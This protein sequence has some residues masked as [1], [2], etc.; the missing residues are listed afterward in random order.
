MEPWLDLSLSASERANALL[1]ELSLDEKMA[2][3][4]CLFPYEDLYQDYDA[5]ETL[6]PFGIGEVSNLETQGAE[7]LEAAAC[8][9]RK[10]Q[11][12]VMANSPHRIP[13]IFHMEGLCGAVLH[14]ATSFPSGLARGSAFDPELEEAIG[15]TVSRQEAAVG[16]GHILAP[17]LDMARDPRLGRQGE[18]YGEDASLCAALGT[19]Y[20]RGVQKNEVA[21][22]HPE[23]VAKH[24]AAFHTSAGGIHGAHSE[25]SPRELEGSFSKPFQAAIRDAG[26]KGIMPCYCILDGEPAS[27]SKALLT[28]LLRE[29]LGFDGVAVSDYG[30][31]GNA[32]NCQHLCETIGE[33]GLRCLEA[34]TDVEMPSPAGYGPELRELFASGAADLSILDRAVQRV[35]EAKFRIG[36]FE[37]PFALEGERLRQTV[38]HEKEDRELTLRSAR[39]SLVLLKNDS[40]L[41][42]SGQIR[43]LAVIGP[44][45]DCARKMF[46]GY[47]H[48]S[49]SESTLAVAN[50]I[51]GVNG[52]RH[53]DPSSIVTVP[54]S[55]I[56][57]D[58]G[59]EF[60]AIL[61]RQ[62]PDC[63]SLLEELRLRLP[64]TEIRY[65]YGY[66]IAGADERGF[67][68]ALDAIREADAAILTLGGKYGTCSIASM[69]EGVDGT[70]INLPACQD[71]FI[72]AAAALG[73]PLIGL[74]F[75]GR[76]ISSDAADEHLSA[77]LECWTPAECG[78]QA[79]TD[80]LVGEVNPSGKLPVTV[81]RSAA[82]LPIYYDHPWN[83]MW[84]Q[85]GSIGFLN[86]VDMPHTP[87]YCFGHGLSYTAF[88]YSDLQFSRSEIAPD[89]SL[90][91]SAVI[92]N[93]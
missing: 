24:F 42:L 74:H 27:A 62:K 37:H 50:S 21:G 56:Q 36:L 38:V 49:M 14:D 33:T 90:D 88:V 9:Q 20:V 1:K 41:P 3:I 63:R 30:A 59:A 17:V 12:I 16:V 72:C 28:G 22:R 85:S 73:K 40:A 13:A 46:G 82:Q 89:A 67:D 58:E 71:A 86:Y 44:H 45:A 79:V 75:D 69:G 57:S 34:G 53:A 76:P 91:I 11:S 66:P 92:T 7:T 77:I 39:E 54:G 55:F 19:A 80:V 26:L 52:T 15:E 5:I 32:H 93:T 61:M 70:D 65:A 2:Q 84:H 47:T 83:S 18:S 35:L 51:A 81:A 29:K 23:S 10:V 60:D 64:D 48:L 25:V 87:R 31:I 8:W 6:T 68:E 43:K 4:N 78:A